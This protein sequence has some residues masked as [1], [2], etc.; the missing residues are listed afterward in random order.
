MMPSLSQDR[1][2]LIAV[3]LPGKEGP[4]GGVSAPRFRTVDL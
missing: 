1:A 3:D 4:Q 2:V